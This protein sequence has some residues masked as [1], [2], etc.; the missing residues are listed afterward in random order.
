LYYTPGLWEQ[1][2]AVFWR[3]LIFETPFAFFR[4]FFWLLLPIMIVLYLIFAFKANKQFK[5]TQE[6]K[7][8]K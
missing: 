1:T 3:S 5:K 7:P 2:G 4:G 6:D 8:G